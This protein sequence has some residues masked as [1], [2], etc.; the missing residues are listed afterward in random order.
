VGVQ[1][2]HMKDISAHLNSSLSKPLV[3]LI[4]LF[5]FIHLNLFSGETSE[6]KRF[7]KKAWT[8]VYILVYWEAARIKK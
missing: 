6:F 1:T 8:Q 2:G 7:S 4:F 3:Q 5:L